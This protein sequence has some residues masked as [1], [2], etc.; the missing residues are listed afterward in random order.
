M[1][2]NFF[3]CDF[4]EDAEEMGWFLGCV[5]RGIGLVSRKGNFVFY[6]TWFEG[7]FNPANKLL[8]R[9]LSFLAGLRRCGSTALARF[10]TFCCSW[11]FWLKLRLVRN[12]GR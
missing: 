2:R 5:S 3:G 11:K 6:R 4:F 7:D 9:Y 12:D 1:G 8:G 10:K